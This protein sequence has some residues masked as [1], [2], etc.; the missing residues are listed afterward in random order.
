MDRVKYRHKREI[1]FKVVTSLVL[2]FICASL[3]ALS[4]SGCYLVKQGRYVLKYST[5][6]RRIDKMRQSADTPEEL[7][8][9]FSLVD[10]VR[11]FAADSLGLSKNDNYSTYIEIPGDRVVN[12]VYAAGK[13]DFKPY[14]WKFPF[15]G[16][17][18][19]K[20]FFESRDARKEAGRLAA[21][22]Y[23]TCVLGAGAF[24]TLGFFSDPVYS[25]MKRYSTFGLA[26]LIFHEQTHATLFIKSQLQFNEELATFFGKEGAL[27][28]VRGKFGD[29]SEQFRKALSSIHDEDVFYNLM[30]SL[31]KSLK[32][33][34]DSAGLSDEIKLELKQKIIS[35]FKDSIDVHYDSL[36]QSKGYRWL[37]KSTINNATLLA[38]MTYN[39]NLSL[40]RDLYERKNRDFK[41]LLAGL[42]TLKKKKGDLH[43]WIGKL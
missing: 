18:P 19:N 36:F 11:R 29:T 42:K 35:R 1:K 41:A 27:R 43:E 7:K 31:H 10:E 16:S 28:F 40:F 5:E 37:T 4:L 34:Y 32:E 17:W 15:F 26:Y 33:V 9:F 8:A 38:D 25:Y 22:G 14:I 12:V 21:K 30:R 6:A 3:C 2:C 24:S 23:D 13:F 39:Q 20:G